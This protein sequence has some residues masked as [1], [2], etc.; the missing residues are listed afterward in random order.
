MI[1]MVTP[2]GPNPNLSASKTQKQLQMISMMRSGKNT[3]AQIKNKI[4]DIIDGTTVTIVMALVTLFALVG[5]DFRVW[6]TM[7]KS[8][9]FFDA[10]L[11]ISMFLFSLEILMNT[12]VMDDFKY[13]Y[14]FW[15]D[16]IATIS[17]IMD[18]DMILDQI[19][20][21]VFTG[22]PSYHTVNA[23]H[24]HEV[25]DSSQDKIQKLLKSL[26]LIRL[27]RIIKLYKYAI[28]SKSR[29]DDDDMP[30]KKKKKKED[31]VEMSVFMKETDPSKL[32][33][34]LVGVIN[35]QTI[36]IILFMLMI[37]PLLTN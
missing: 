35:R 22:T 30:S 37:F 14:F 23:S 36:T 31:D 7:K 9:P 34:A 10:T 29:D 6:L 16:I 3:D 26:R 33:K 21:Y 15:L 11:I 20:V 24:D 25:A 4:R 18:I 8:D 2:G 13:S 5:D 17:L 19:V 1:E 28:K 12:I 32:A 27:I